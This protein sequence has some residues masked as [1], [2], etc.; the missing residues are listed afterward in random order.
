MIREDFSAGFRSQKA[1]VEPFLRIET[2]I[3]QFRIAIEGE[4]CYHQLPSYGEFEFNFNEISLTPVNEMA[5]S[6]L[7]I[8]SR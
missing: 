1:A 8:K 3:I 7:F 5:T 6:K 2:T 4:N